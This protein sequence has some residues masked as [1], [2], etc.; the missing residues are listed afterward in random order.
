MKRNIKM[1][2][3]KIILI[4]SILFNSCG[5]NV[6]YL[7]R[8][9]YTGKI[10][11]KEFICENYDNLNITIEE[12]MIVN[13]Q[14]DTFLYTS[15]TDLGLYIKLCVKNESDKTLEFLIDDGINNPAY[16]KWGFQY[17]NKRDTV[18]FY[19][20]NLDSK[21]YIK[22]DDSLIFQLTAP[23]YGFKK[24]FKDKEDYS[25]DMLDLISQLNLTYNIKQKD[26]CINQKSK[27]KIGVANRKSKWSWW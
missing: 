16:F 6:K 4:I 8:T 15:H 24:L 22:A 10:Y 18:E 3:Y 2:N 14:K 27:I 12:V 13:T 23:F 1:V 20:K 21:N 25:E 17:K 19:S 7:E 9:D 11:F 5:H 26:I